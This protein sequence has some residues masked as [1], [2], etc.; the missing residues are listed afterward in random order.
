[1]AILYKNSDLIEITDDEQSHATILKVNK[2]N[3][4][5]YFP[6]AWEKEPNGIKNMDEF[7]KYLD[8]EIKKLNDP[9]VINF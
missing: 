1:M 9:L 6:V 4:D 8:I 5:Y 3:L 7:Q 2:G